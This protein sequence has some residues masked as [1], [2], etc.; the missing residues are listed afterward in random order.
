LPT[1]GFFI[2]VLKMKMTESRRDGSGP[3]RYCSLVTDY[4][5]ERVKKFAS[6]GERLLPPC[7]ASVE[8][9]RWGVSTYRSPADSIFSHLLTYA[10]GPVIAS[11]PSRQGRRSNLI[12][13]S[14]PK[15]QRHEIASSLRSSQ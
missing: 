12:L 10:A 5:S 13:L 15:G 7:T 3:G 8:T 9:P 6:A 1:K 2:I 14:L 4:R 11:R